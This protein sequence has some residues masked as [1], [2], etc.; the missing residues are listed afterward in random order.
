MKRSNI[1]IALILILFII[2]MFSLFLMVKSFNNKDLE[3]IKEEHKV[4]NKKFSMYIKN[5]SGAYIPYN[6]TYLFPEGYSL[7]LEKSSCVD[8]NG[9]KIDNMLVNNGDSITITSNKTIYCY[10]Y[11]DLITD[12][13]IISV[14][15]DGEYGVMPSSGSYTNSATCNS[16]NIIWNQKYQRIEIGDFSSK[17]TKCNITFTKDTSPKTLLKDK[18]EEVNINNNYNSHGYRYSGKQPDNWVWFNGE[19]WRIIGSIPTCTS[20]GCGTKENLVKII[21]NDSLG[22]YAYDASSTTSA[23]LKGAWGSN[24]LYELLNTYYYA[25]DV[26]AMNGQSHK[27][28][29]SCY[30]SNY[31][32]RPNCDYSEIGILSSSY[33][34]KM[35]KNVYWNTGASAYDVTPSTAYTNETKKQTAS[36]HVGLMTPS[37]WGYAASSSYHSIPMSSYTSSGKRATETSW[38]FNNGYE[39]T[40]IRY[41]SNNNNALLVNIDG[42]IYYSDAYVGY[43]VRPIVYLD[44]SVYIVS[45]DGTEANPYQIGM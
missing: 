21:R 32:P 18:V 4:N 34:G 25:S 1:K 23:N 5:E 17:Q 42:N 20:S 28:C 11:L 14:D 38:I 40:S 19:K 6:D 27:G 36:G 9:Q 44:S 2:E 45:G 15:T 35:V 29:Y 26:T 3:K 16:G 8:T 13:I 39:W 33:Y 31:Q 22:A 41:N 10:L 12:D 43:A 30:A 37:D 7:N 24:T